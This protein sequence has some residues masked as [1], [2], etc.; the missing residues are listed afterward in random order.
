MNVKQLIEKLNKIPSDYD[1]W[2]ENAFG[3]YTLTPTIEVNEHAE[4]VIIEGALRID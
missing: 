1:I 2:I 3:S 4:I